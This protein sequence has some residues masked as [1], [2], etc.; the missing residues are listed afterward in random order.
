MNYLQKLFINSVADMYCDIMT[1][2][3]NTGKCTYLYV[4]FGKAYEVEVPIAWDIAKQLLMDNICPEDRQRVLDTWDEKLIPEAEIDSAFSIT[5]RTISGGM[6]R[7]GGEW[8][9]HVSIQS[10]STGKR[11]II[12]SRDHSMQMRK[13]L[14]LDSSIRKDPVTNLYNHFKLDEMIATEYRKMDSC[15][16]LFFDINDF[17][18]RKDVYGTKEEEGILRNISEGVREIQN[19]N[20]AAYRYGRD[21]FLVIAKDYT[22][23][24]F[25][26]LINLWVEKWGNISTGRAI[27]YT[28][29]MGNAWD[30]AP[31]SVGELIAKAEGHMF[32]NKKLMQSGIPMDYYL[33]E[34]ISSSYGLFG[35][36][37]FFKTVDY[38]LKADWEG[39]SL[40]A[41]DIEHFKLYN[42]WWGRQ[43][44]DEFLADVALV[45]K[46]YESRYDG[47]ASYLGGDNFAILLPDNQE[48]IKALSKALSILANEKTNNV[49]FMPAL[50]IYRTGNERVDAMVMY[51][52]ATEA[53]TR[54][55]GNYEKR[56]CT[57][58]ENMTKEVEN[59]LNL[60][61]EA[62]EGLERRQFF[63][64]LQPKCNIKTGQVVGGEALVRWRHPLKGMVSP[65]EFIPVLERN[66]FITDLDLFVW[67]EVCR[68]I[69]AWMDEGIEP[70]PLSINV[71]RIDML[72]I[73]VVSELN[74]MVKKHGIDREYVKVEI[75]ESAYV[76]DADQIMDTVNR[77]RESGFILL[78]DDFGSGYSSLNMLRNVI[79]D[80]IKIDMKFLDIGEDE[81]D[82]GQQILKSIIKMSQEMHLPIIVEGVETQEQVDFLDSMDVHFAQG[83]FFYRPI[84]VDDFTQI[85]KDES[86]VDHV[87]IT[88]EEKDSGQFKEMVET[89]MEENEKQKNEYKL[90]R[91]VGG[92]FSYYAKG[93]GELIEID[94]SVAR[95]YGFDT[96]DELREYTGNS[97]KGMVHP[98]DWECVEREIREQIS[99]SEWKMDCV[100]YRIIRKD[101][102]IRYA[103]DYGHLEGEKGNEVFKVLLLDITEESNQEKN[104]Q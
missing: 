18:N 84:E 68:K 89:L 45:L 10:T 94:R 34:E 81:L 67:E 1:I 74:R 37:Q 16:V 24:A 38:R 50:G 5:Y 98:D 4:E 59:E 17:R 39:Y 63:I 44:G 95:M 43:A 83:Y 71:S 49:G 47:I 19:S 9:M 48:I 78:M 51:D 56:Y 69:R 91:V 52:R 14:N 101:G 62:R 55:F 20:V 21:N 77:L 85:L 70:V 33:Q 65:G 41:I 76:D 7:D 42:K 35:A 79:V 97:F 3:L 36:T 66:G 28:V 104:E 8:K 11:A 12:Y 103:R 57:Y 102:S 88:V 31:V 30:C 99:D 86:K 82:K 53:Q 100:E 80:I 27:E 29:A 6:G 75:T 15:G 13:K 23:E 60:L 92:F 87:G 54:V 2:D 73:D 90:Y 61:I 22:K 46:D 26:N 96:V 64:V 72:S 58:E 25:R 93:E 40:V 32:R